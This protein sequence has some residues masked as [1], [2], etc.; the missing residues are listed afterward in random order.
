M[1]EN[2]SRCEK[3]LLMDNT[4]LLLHPVRLRIVQAV[5]DG[6]RFTT[7]ELCERLPDVSKATV[8]RQVA[9]LA[10]GGLFEVDSEK[11]VRGAVER[12]YRLQRARAVIDADAAAAMTTEDHRRGFAAVVAS[13]LAEF[14]V[15]LARAGIDPLADKVSYP[16][17]S[18]WLSDAEKAAL[19][20]EVAA[21]LRAR[22]ANGP[23]P[24]R[25]RHLLTTILFPV[26]D[27]TATSP[28]PGSA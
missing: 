2:N 24:G 27:G 17:F 19:I 28:P 1:N 13:L 6:R 7:S 26:E 4:E 15:Y 16:Q 9:L 3:M 18:L 12:R 23:A 20:D 21:S 8:Y 25:R 22:A 10:E 11:R 5:L 14:D